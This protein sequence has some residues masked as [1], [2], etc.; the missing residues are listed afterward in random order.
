MSHT[1]KLIGYKL[2]LK[3]GS[4]FEKGGED[5]KGES[6]KGIFLYKERARY[7]IKRR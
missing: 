4:T 5:V 3:N 2:K 7:L 1:N 6:G